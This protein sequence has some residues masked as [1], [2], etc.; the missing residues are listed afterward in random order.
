MI[1]TI[2]M[3]IGGWQANTH[4]CHSDKVAYLKRN[5]RYKR[6]DKRI[7]LRYYLLM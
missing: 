7:H 4:E 3:N 5:A 6:V 1:K 2:Q